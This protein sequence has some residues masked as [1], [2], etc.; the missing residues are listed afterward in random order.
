M[1]VKVIESVGCADRVS[2][3]TLEEHTSLPYVLFVY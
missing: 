2:G 3:N 1:N